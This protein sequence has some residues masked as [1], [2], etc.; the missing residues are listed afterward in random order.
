MFMGQL[1]GDEEKPRG[2][3]LATGRGQAAGSWED[4]TD[5]G[6]KRAGPGG[7]TAGDAMGMDCPGREGWLGKG[8]GPTGLTPTDPN[9]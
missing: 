4:G 5:A 7:G 3:W 9:G 8:A 1:N 2:D 6:V